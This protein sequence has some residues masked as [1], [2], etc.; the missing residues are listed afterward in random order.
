MHEVQTDMMRDF[1]GVWIPKAVWLDD[2]LSALE[3]M[4]LAEIDSLD[5]GSDG[6]Y[7]SNQYIAGFCQCSCTKVSLSVSKLVSLGYVTSSI[8][9]RARVLKSCLSKSED[10]LSKNESILSESESQPFKNCK[11][12]FQ[13]VKDI[14][15]EEN[16]KDIHK[17][18]SFTRP[19]VDEVRAY[20]LERE[21]GVD[22]DRFVA[23]YTANGWKVGKNPM[24]D[25]RAAVRTWEK[26]DRGKAAGKPGY[27]AQTHN[28]QISD[29]A[30]EAVKRLME[31]T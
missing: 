20:C 14:N 2:R 6:C 7:A 26:N 18:D 4:I 12:A 29:Y 25:W 5:C 11:P 28:G 21:N 9:N 22:A 10:M 30:K 15:I 17:R 27:R 8:H 13:K 19:S 1:K 3:K 24:R 16:N 23:Y 31:E